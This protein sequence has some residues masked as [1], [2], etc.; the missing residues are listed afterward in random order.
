MPNFI[1]VLIFFQFSFWLES[2]HPGL[3]ADTFFCASPPRFLYPALVSAA[4]KPV[5]WGP[6]PPQRLPSVQPGLPL[7]GEC[8]RVAEGQKRS[9][10]P[11]PSLRHVT[12][13]GKEGGG[14]GFLSYLLPGNFLE[15]LKVPLQC[16]I[17]QRTSSSP[18]P[19]GY[20][21]RARTERGG[22]AR[23]MQRA[24][25]LLAGLLPSFLSNYTGIVPSEQRNCYNLGY[26]T[27]L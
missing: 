7:S 8:R 14:Q 4:R 6:A 3:G 2:W 16:N 24:Q 25:S 5:G 20:L 11:S 1:L 9:P 12:T 17:T 27:S 15:H 26:K 19:V 18:P 10:S 23:A 22:E 21:P 13:L